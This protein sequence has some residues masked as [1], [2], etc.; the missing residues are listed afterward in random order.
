MQK[1]SPGVLS[2][3]L[4]DAAT[5]ASNGV[6]RASR[7]KAPNAL[8]ASTSSPRECSA[9]I[10]GDRLDGIH[11]SGGRLAVDRRDVGGPRIVRD[12]RG[13]GCRG[14]TGV[15]SGASSSAKRRPATSQIF[16]MRCP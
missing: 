2:R 10:A 4:P 13:R 3:H 7:G 15:S 11:D 14:S 5:A 6:E 8:I 16:A 12:G 1:P 9:Q